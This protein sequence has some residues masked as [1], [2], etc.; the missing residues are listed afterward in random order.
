MSALNSNFL[1]RVLCLALVL[2]VAPAVPAQADTAPGAATRKFEEGDRAL[3][4]GHFQAALKLFLASMELEPS[5]NTR[6]Q[7]AACYLALGKSA[8][9]YSNFKRAAQEADDR[10]S[11]TGERR[12][13]A[14]RVAAQSKVRELEAKVPRVRLEVPA[15]APSDYTILL[16]GKPIPRPAWGDELEIDPGQHELVATAA[17]IKRHSLVFELRASER[18]RI[19]IPLERLPT[20][21]VRIHLKTKPAGLTVSIDDNAVSPEDLGK[22]QYLDVG[23]HKLVARAPGYSDFEWRGFL[24]DGDE[25]TVLVMLKPGGSGPPRWVTFALG[26]AT[27]TTLAVGI[28]FGIKAQRAADEQLQMPDPLL[29][30]IQ[31]QDAIRTDA[32]IANVF[33]GIAGLM[34]INTAIVAATTKWPAASTP[35]S[36]KS[37]H[38]RPTF[39]LVPIL[40]RDLKSLAFLGVF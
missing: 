15:D 18:R 12:Y 26:G 31:T 39:T 22:V 32:I 33:Y 34:A 40:M 27:L 14:T 3:Q 13:I 10:A 1:A 4:A 17:H 38:Q 29:R 7:I 21:T 8:S 37:S 23:N 16:D 28:G 9:A 20:G 6:F 2:A 11:A 19:N 36:E 25:V 5:P 24:L 35:K 30:S